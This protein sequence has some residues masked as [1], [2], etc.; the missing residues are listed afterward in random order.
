[1]QRTEI[2]RT[3]LLEEPVGGTLM[4]LAVPMIFGILSM[5]VYNLADTFFVGR[6]GKE[7]LA[8]LS[9][10]FP[11]VLTVSSLAQGIGMGASAVV[12]RAIG[13]KDYQ[14]V[15]RLASDSLSLGLLVVSIGAVAGL[16]TIRPLFSLLGAG[17]VVLEYIEQ[18]MRVWYIGML[19]V[20]VPM[21]GNNIIR[22]TGDSRTPGIIMVIGAAANLTLDP[23]LIFGP[24]PFPALGI[25]GAA[26]ATLIGRG[27]TF[28]IAMFV[29]AVREKLLAYNMPRPGEIWESWREILHIGVP[30]AA[31]KM[32]IPLGNGF[33]TRVVASYG[34]AAV[35]GYGVGVRVEFFSLAALNALSSVVGPFIGQNL[36]AGRFQRVE[37]GFA[38]SGRFSL[39]VGGGLFLIYLILAGKI[40]TLFNPDTQ[41]VATASLY[42]R[43]VSFAYAAQGFYLVASAGLNVMKRPLQAAGL[44]LLEMFVLSV[45][46][47]LLGSHLFGTAGVFTAVAFSYTATGLAALLLVRRVLKRYTAKAPC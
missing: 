31:T 38:T 26:A 41:V 23:L 5:V 7:Q 13:S 36:G 21:V 17:G 11:V 1:M 29:L 19:F 39:Y 25:Q 44:S 20:V 32:I 10:T 12:S 6:L 37:A 35:A 47:A 16:F 43:I 42:L 33:I 18:Y 28:L 46:L 27:A 24:G 30:N 34:A 40:A 4:R 3:R 8:V 2:N 14:R 9:F 22:A 45:P 15:R